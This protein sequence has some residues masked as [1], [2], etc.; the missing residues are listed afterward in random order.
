MLKAMFLPLV[1]LTS[2]CSRAQPTPSVSPSPE[3]N[4]VLVIVNSNSPMSEELGRFY[5]RTRAIPAK[6]LL[7]VRIGT[8]DD[9]SYADCKNK[10]LAP[11][12]DKLASTPNIKYIVL[13]KGMPLRIW[14]KGKLSIDGQVAVVALPPD[15]LDKANA[16]TDSGTPNPY[17]RKDEHFEPSKYGFFLVTRLDGYDAT[18]VRRLILDSTLAKPEKGLFFFDA[19]GGRAGAYGELHDSLLNA[20]EVLKQKGFDAK[21]ENTPAFVAPD[22]ALAGYASWGSNDEQFSLDTY[23]R[24]RFKP[25]SLAET[26]VSTSGRTFTRTTGGQSLIADLIAQGV[27]G[28]KGYVSE[29]Y[30]FALAHPDILF[31]RYTSGYTLAESFYMAS[32]MIR[33]KDVVVG[34]PLCAPY[35]R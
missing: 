29:P 12:R 25:G 14:D 34:D 8:D 16:N 6:N 23:H 2:A 24:L 27:T 4:R 32:P 19:K 5:I 35:R 11:L 10:L 1:L 21:T 3:S 31:D 22:E 7:E 15:E 18:D 17:Y 28:M 20:S 33:W 26:F 30:T 13:V 9:T